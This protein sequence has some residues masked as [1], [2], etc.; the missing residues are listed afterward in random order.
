MKR[1]LSTL[2]AATL[3]FAAPWGWPVAIL[4]AAITDSLSAFWEMEEAS[5]TREDAHTG[6]LDLSDNNTVTS[7][8]GKVGTAASFAVASDEFLHAAD[9]P[10][11]S[12]GTGVSLTIAA[13]VYLHTDATE[14]HIVTKWDAVNA[15][16]KEWIVTYD[17]TSDRFRFLVR[18][19]DSVITNLAADT[20]GA[21]ST[22]TWYFVVAQF[23][24]T[25]SILSIN[26]NNGTAD[27]VDTAQSDIAD[28]AAVFVVGGYD[29][30]ASNDGTMDGRVDQVGIWKRILTTDE[31]TALYNGGNGQSF[32]QMTSPGLPGSMMRGLIGR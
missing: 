7:N 26:V 6:N 25:T 24:H 20:F 27:T 3:L 13:W 29:N 10:A 17:P 30:G 31:L 21:V 1:I 14:S 18:H 9:A 32:A 2:V 23:T 16:V 28:T 11:L 15:T 19:G 12:A 8:T 4:H 22:T 5:G